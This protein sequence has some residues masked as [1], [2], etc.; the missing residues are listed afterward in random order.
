MQRTGQLGW[1]SLVPA[2]RSSIVCWGRAGAWHKQ[3]C[4]KAVTPHRQP[5]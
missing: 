5:T 2:G 1:T 4:S 3:G